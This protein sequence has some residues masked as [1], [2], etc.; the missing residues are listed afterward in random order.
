MARAG[1]LSVLKRAASPAAVTADVRAEL[2]RRADEM[3]PAIVEALADWLKL[4]RGGGRGLRYRRLGLGAGEASVLASAGAKDIAVLDERAAR[5]L[6]RSIGI[7]HTGLIGL[8]VDAAQDGRI[9]AREARETIDALNA[10]GFWLA[11]AL[12]DGARDRVGRHS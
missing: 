6:A 8:L 5:I 4:R 10:S 9:S 2:L 12:L 1:K 7:R 11:P 3:T